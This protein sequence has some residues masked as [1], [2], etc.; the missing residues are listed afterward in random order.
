MD[1]IQRHFKSLLNSLHECWYLNEQNPG[2]FGGSFSKLLKKYH[3][4]SWEE[5]CDM[6]M[7]KNYF[8]CLQDPSKPVSKSAYYTHQLHLVLC[9]L[10]KYWESFVFSYSEQNKKKT[11]ETYN[12]YAKLYNEFA[13]KAKKD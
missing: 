9:E 3:K 4:I 11:A 6:V 12:A 13:K 5:E 7:D 10:P 8:D 2:S 1:E